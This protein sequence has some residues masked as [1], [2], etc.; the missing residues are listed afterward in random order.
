MVSTGSDAANPPTVSFVSSSLNRPNA[1]GA[2]SG[3]H[4]SFQPQLYE[5]PYEI[6][7]ILAFGESCQRV[8]P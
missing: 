1:M 6:L 2:L 7:T 8:T 4:S 5:E 3:A